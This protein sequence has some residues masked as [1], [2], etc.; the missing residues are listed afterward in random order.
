MPQCL[1]LTIASGRRYWLMA[2]RAAD[3]CR[4]Q[5][6]LDTRVIGKVTVPPLPHNDLHPSFWRLWLWDIV[7]LEV[8]T[9]LWFDADTYFL[10]PWP[11]LE[12]LLATPGFSARTDLPTM[13]LLHECEEH[14]LLLSRY[15]NAGVFV[16]HRADRHVFELAKRIAT[17]P[18]YRS[19]YL[20]Q[21]A[22]NEALQR[23]NVELNLLNPRFNAICR[24]SMLPVDPVVIHRAGGGRNRR[25]AALFEQL[26]ADSRVPV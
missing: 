11:H 22:L 3:S 20:E 23:S 21:T 1:A 13:P 8:E 2:L 26:I 15:V 24:P 10:R 7:P 5:T 16:T 9:V 25:N 19:R 14:G 18:Q 4:R 12:Q 17:D 6:G